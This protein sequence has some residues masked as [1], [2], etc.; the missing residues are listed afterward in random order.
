M[1]VM[2]LFMIVLYAILH[3]PNAQSEECASGLLKRGD[4]CCKPKICDL[5]K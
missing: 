4:I 1:T 3:V 5:S 2:M